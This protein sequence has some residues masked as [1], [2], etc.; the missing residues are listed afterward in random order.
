MMKK[1]E[2]FFFGEKFCKKKI[3]LKNGKILFFSKKFQF[4]I[5]LSF[6]GKGSDLRN[7]RD[8]WPKESEK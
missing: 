8:E 7:L 2:I 6:S 3:L 4:L 1:V 5:F